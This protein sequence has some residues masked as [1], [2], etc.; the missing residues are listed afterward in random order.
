MA[1]TKSGEVVVLA[2]VS[3]A[4]NA[5]TVGSGIDV[6]TYYSGI[7]RIRMG[8][9]TGSAF[10]VGPKVRVEVSPKTSPTANDWIALTSFV[11]ALGASIG[12]TAVSGTEAVGQTVVSLTSGTNFT[13]GD[14]IFFHNATIGSSEWSRVVSIATNDITIEEGLVNAQTGATARDQAE[15]YPCSVDLVGINRLRVVVDGAGSGQAVICE[16]TAGFVSSL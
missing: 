12:S 3:T 15:Q 16:V 1:L 2:I 11:M 14:Y 4:S 8:R 7:L 6:S 9:G 5:V 10:T 13:A